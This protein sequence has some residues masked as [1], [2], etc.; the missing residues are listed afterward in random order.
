[1]VNHPVTTSR[2]WL[3]ASAVIARLEEHHLT[4]ADF[5]DALGLSRSY[6]SQLVHRKRPLSPQVRRAL[7]AASALAGLTEDQI[8]DRVRGGAQP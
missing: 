4:H 7:L 3:N 5:A 2:F 1:M 6:W 8:W